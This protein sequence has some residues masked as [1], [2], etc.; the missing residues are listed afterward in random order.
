MKLLHLQD[1]NPHLHLVVDLLLLVHLG[2]DLLLQGHLGLDL[3]LQGTKGHSLLQDLPLDLQLLVH[4]MTQEIILDGC[5]F[6]MPVGEEG[7]DC[8][9][10]AFGLCYL[11]P[12]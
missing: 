2:L 6:L 11:K 8:H 10:G 4:L 7:T 3:L 9:E 12:V 1:H 5:P